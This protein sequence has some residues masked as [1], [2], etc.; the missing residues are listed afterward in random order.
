MRK[1]LFIALLAAGCANAGAPNLHPV[2][3][4]LPGEVIAAERA[5]AAR[6]PASAWLNPDAPRFWDH[7]TV[8]LIGNAVP[9]FPLTVDGLKGA[10]K[11][12]RAGGAPPR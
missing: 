2:R 3:E 5:F 9:M 11:R 4:A 10:V 1:L 12:L 8:R 6:A 7:P